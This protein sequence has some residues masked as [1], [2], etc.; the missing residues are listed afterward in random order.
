MRSPGGQGHCSARATGGTVPSRGPAPVALAAACLAATLAAGC[1]GP[2][3]RTPPPGPGSDAYL[4]GA[5]GGYPV[6]VAAAPAAPA[7]PAGSEGQ[8]LDEMLGFVEGQVITRRAIVRELGER[9]PTQDERDYEASIG[10][11]VRMRAR[12]W[13]F[14]KAAESI[15]LSLPPDTL[16]DIADERGKKEA[17]LASEREGRTVSFDEILRERGQTR[18]EYR[19]SI[20]NYVLVQHYLQVLFEGVPGKRAVID[21]EPSPADVRRIYAAHREAFDVKAGVRLA[22]WVV[23]T[24]EFLKREGV[25]YED[26]VAE[27]KRRAVAIVGA[28][29]AGKTPEEAAQQCEVAKGAVLQTQMLEVG[30]LPKAMPSVYPGYTRAAEVEA[31][32]FDP[33]RRVGDAASF[34]GPQ[35]NPMAVYVLELQPAR[36]RTFDEVTVDPKTG[37][38]TSVKD[39]VLYLIRSTRRRRAVEQHFLDRLSRATVQPAALRRALEDDSRAELAKLDA[40]P[41][42]RDIKLR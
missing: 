10:N 37:E 15:G 23:P 2:G 5:G 21:V 29:R 20:K 30:Q 38:P 24:A 22:W 17:R 25:K 39:E 19:A 28:V 27:A 7:P 13:V 1:R 9:E 4:G 18:G 42:M 36:R 31:W 32:A 16:D 14:V 12:E 33:A 40:D 8:N 11:R 3:A 35:D 34:L 41:L 26:A 6:P